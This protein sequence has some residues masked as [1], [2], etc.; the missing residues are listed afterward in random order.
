MALYPTRYRP[1]HPRA[2]SSGCVY[3]HVLIAEAALGRVLP[4]GV[5]VHHVDGDTYHNAPGNLV[6]CED[7]RYHRLLHV[8]ARILRLGGDPNRDAVC[9]R[10]HEVKP[11]E[12]FNERAGNRATGRQ[13][14]CRAC[15]NLWSERR[16]DVYATP[17]PRADHRSR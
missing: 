1:E 3:L 2:T 4:E 11:R 10:C 9:S 14:Y 16:T 5:E 15:A 7:H 13:S 8:R 6:V 17:L 12:A